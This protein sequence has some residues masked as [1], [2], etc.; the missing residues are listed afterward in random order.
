MFT[1]NN[2]LIYATFNVDFLFVVKKE[3]G[4]YKSGCNCLMTSDLESVWYRYT[5]YIGDVGDLKGCR[6][7]VSSC[8]FTFEYCVCSG[9][10]IQ[11]SVGNC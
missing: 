5:R 4:L 11:A 10:D 1:K 3:T 9:L 6:L 7:P 2:H 8:R